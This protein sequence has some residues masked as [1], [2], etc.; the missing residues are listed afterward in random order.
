MVGGRGL[1]CLCTRKF[2]QG[3][4]SI[5]ERMTESCLSQHPVCTLPLLGAAPGSEASGPCHCHHAPPS[6]P[7]TAG[8]WASPAPSWPGSGMSP[9]PAPPLPLQEVLSPQM[10]QEVTPGWYVQDAPGPLH[11]G[12]PAQ[13]RADP[14]SCA[15]SNPLGSPLPGSKPCQAAHVQA[16]LP[17]PHAGPNRDFMVSIS[18]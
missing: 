13:S 2:Q 4:W 8:L 9:C 5:S 7:P 14:L 17:R 3:H 15:F 16:F 10:K 18:P 1:A 12:S 6:W 11:P